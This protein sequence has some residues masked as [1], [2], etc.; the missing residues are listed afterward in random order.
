[1]DYDEPLEQVE[2]FIVKDAIGSIW[3]FAVASWL[4]DSVVGLVHD[5]VGEDMITDPGSE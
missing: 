2:P 3:R 1:L 4:I 5:P